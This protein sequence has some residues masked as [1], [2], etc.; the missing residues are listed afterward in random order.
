[1]ASGQPSATPRRQILVWLLRLAAAVVL[2]YYLW[3]IMYF[4]LGAKGDPHGF[5]LLG[6]IVSVA[7]VALAAAVML[8]TFK[9][10]LARLAAAFLLFFSGFIYYWFAF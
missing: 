3:D 5:L 10:N 9:G 6:T 4:S 7:N 1:M 8:A 2:A